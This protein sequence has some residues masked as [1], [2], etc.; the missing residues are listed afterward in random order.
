MRPVMLVRDAIDRHAA[1]ADS[2]RVSLEMK[3]YPDIAPVL[4]DRRSMRS[5]LDN[6]IANAITFTPEAG[7]VTIDAREKDNF[8]I[9]QVRDTGVGIPPERLP[10]IFSRFASQRADGKGTG[11]GLALVRRLVELQ[12]GQVSAESKVGE[13]S[14]FSFTLPLAPSPVVR[15]LVEEG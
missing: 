12:G 2:K 1:A 4:A 8:V 10:R 9:F 11:L 14:T 6:L 7:T 3:V 15:H 13:G 5:V